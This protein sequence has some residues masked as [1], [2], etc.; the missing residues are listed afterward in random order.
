MI[1]NLIPVLIV[2]K[3]LLII[4]KPIDM[5]F[6]NKDLLDG[7]LSQLRAEKGHIWVSIIAPTH[8]Q[9]PERA[10]DP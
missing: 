6:L 9:S 10:A 1:Q 8:H 2:L 4:L 5:Q 3:N 7:G